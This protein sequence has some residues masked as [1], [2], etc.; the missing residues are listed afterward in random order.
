[1]KSRSTQS[2]LSFTT[3]TKT[4]LTIFVS[5]HIQTLLFYFVFV[6]I[7]GHQKNKQTNNK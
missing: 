6:A 2:L 4:G 3:P 7:A 5:S 1:M